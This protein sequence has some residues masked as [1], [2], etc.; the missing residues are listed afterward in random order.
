MDNQESH[1]N[2]HERVEPHIEH[3]KD[4]NW[5]LCFTFADLACK[6]NFPDC[7]LFV[8]KLAYDYKR[9]HLLGIAGWY[10][11]EFEKGKIGCLK[12][13]ESGA[14]Q[15]VDRFNL[16]FYLEREEKNKQLETEMKK[17][18]LLATLKEQHP[19]LPFSNSLEY[20]PAIP[21]RCHLL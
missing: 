15:D 19:I 13:L 4:L 11:N 7:L 10:S 9:W 18:K 5:I 6:V 20:H 2:S 8:D 1:I 14:G 17:A 21:R 3:Y 12:A 16:K